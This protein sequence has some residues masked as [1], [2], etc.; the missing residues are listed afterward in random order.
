MPR[1]VHIALKVEYEVLPAFKLSEQNRGLEVT[2][3]F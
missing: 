2:Y 3:A 1:V